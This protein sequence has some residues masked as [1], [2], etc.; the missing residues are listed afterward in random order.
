MFSIGG[1]RDGPLGL[2]REWRNLLNDGVCGTVVSVGTALRA[3]LRNQ[4][5]LNM[6]HQLWHNTA[7]GFA[8]QSNA[9]MISDLLIMYTRYI[10]LS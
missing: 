1:K 2:E 6:Q 10:L 9:T 4:F 5:P 7:H 3:I 8:K